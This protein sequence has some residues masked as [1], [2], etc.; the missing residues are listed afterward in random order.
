[1]RLDVPPA[2]L[3]AL[4]ELEWEARLLAMADMDAAEPIDNLDNLEKLINELH[5]VRLLAQNGAR[6]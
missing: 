2:L 6:S 4:R 3:R 1:M 5:E